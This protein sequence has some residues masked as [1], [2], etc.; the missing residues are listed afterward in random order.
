MTQIRQ[1]VKDAFKCDQLVY[2][3]SRIDVEDGHLSSGTMEEVN[4]KF[5][6]AYIVKEAEHHQSISREWLD[7]DLEG[8]DL[9]IHTREYNQLTRFINKYQGA[10]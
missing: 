2:Q 9:K 5:T 1:I 6:D 4:E 10:A 8:E 3:F 7:D